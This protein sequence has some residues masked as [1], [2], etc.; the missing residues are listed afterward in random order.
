MA[1]LASQNLCAETPAMGAVDPASCWMILLETGH[2]LHFSLY[3][4]KM[5]SRLSS[6]R[7][8]AEFFPVGLDF[9][10][11]Q[12]GHFTQDKMYRL[13]SREAGFTNMG[14]YLKQDG[15][16]EVGFGSVKHS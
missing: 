14:Q 2:A 13:D 6:R 11:I 8:F 3:K 15:S 4:T 7:T 16:G 10:L 1:L 12:S 9:K 5:E